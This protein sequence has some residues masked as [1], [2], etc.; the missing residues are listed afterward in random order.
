[1]RAIVAERGQV[2]IPKQ[3]RTKMGIKPGTVLE[4]TIQ[5]GHLVASKAEMGSQIDKVYGC[6]DLGMTTDKFIK[7][8]RGDK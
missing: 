3:L 5:D 6:L 8:I 7:S 2:T 4:F 1:M